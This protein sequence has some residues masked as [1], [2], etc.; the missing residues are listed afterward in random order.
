MQL[1]MLKK[2]GIQNIGVKLGTLIPVSATH[3]TFFRVKGY[4]DNRRACSW[5]V[6]LG[7]NGRKIEKYPSRFYHSN[8]LLNYS[9]ANS[10]SKGL[11]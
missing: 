7:E 5:S 2:A 4:A 6:A 9:Y 10:P 3:A 11:F 8:D 1:R